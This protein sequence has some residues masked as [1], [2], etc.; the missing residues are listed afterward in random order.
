MPNFNYSAE[1]ELFP[2]IRRKFT[3]GPVG[4]KRFTSAAEASGPEII[5]FRATVRFSSRWRAL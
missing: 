4:Y 1:A 2:L 5:S 3:K